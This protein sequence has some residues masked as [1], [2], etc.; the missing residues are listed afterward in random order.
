MWYR[1]KG[2]KEEETE[3]IPSHVLSGR[4]PYRNIY[5][6]R[7]TTAGLCKWPLFSW[8][9]TAPLSWHSTVNRRV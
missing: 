9:L 1:H 7:S 3:R 2:K 4:R 8:S 5:W 6:I